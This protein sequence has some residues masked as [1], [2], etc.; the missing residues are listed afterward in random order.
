MSQTAD[1]LSMCSTASTMISVRG[2]EEIDAES[3]VDR[4]IKDIQQ[5]LNAINVELRNM[6][7]GDER[8][9]EYEEMYPHAQTIFGITKEA[10]TLFKEIE[11]IT[12][13]LL[14]KKPIGFE[15]KISHPC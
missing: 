15:P 5:G 14:G 3:A 9:D 6:L 13:Q 8:D 2:D 1:M 10:K 11:S 7:M 12:R 4:G